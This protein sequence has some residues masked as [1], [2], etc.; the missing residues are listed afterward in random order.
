VP[1]TA[2]DVVQVTSRDRALLVSLRPRFAHAILHGGKSVE[3][4]RQRVAAQ[5]GATLVLYASAPVKAVVGT[6]R[7]ERVDVNT[8]DHVWTE[9]RHRLGLSRD[10]YDDYLQ[11]SQIASALVLT[12]VWPLS[13]PLTLAMLREDD[14]FQPPQSYRYISMTDPQPLR[15]LVM[16]EGSNKIAC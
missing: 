15:T 8:H 12:D 13:D 1:S 5:P 16:A 10:E 7:L 14:Q 4:R 3:L 11:G 2:K 9:H 6:A